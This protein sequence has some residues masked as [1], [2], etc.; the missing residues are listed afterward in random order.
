M[1]D[2]PTVEDTIARENTEANVP[3]AVP[4]PKEPGAAERARHE[5]MHMP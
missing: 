2:F 4:S 1:S 5:L 3:L